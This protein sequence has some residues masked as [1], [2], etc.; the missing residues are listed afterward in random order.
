VTDALLNTLFDYGALGLFAGFLVWM[1]VQSTKRMGD[2][3]ERYDSLLRE[4]LDSKKS[5]HA[6][7]SDSLRALEVK[8]DA[9]TVKIEHLTNH[10]TS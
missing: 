8:V 10:S 3:Q 7:L 6:D 5:G 1:H 4:S 9:Q 2:M